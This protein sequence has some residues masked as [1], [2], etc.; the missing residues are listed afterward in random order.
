M[1]EKML[2]YALPYVAGLII[3]VW[4]Q[5]VTYVTLEKLW[6]K[7][8]IPKGTSRH[9]QYLSAVLGA[10]EGALYLGAFLY[11]KPEFIA[12]WLGLKTVVKWRH[13]EYDVPVGKPTRWI[14]G[15]NAYN[16]FLVGNGL[17]VCFAAAAWKVAELLRAEDHP[18]TYVLLIAIA[19]LSIALVSLA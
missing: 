17:V 1:S 16:L 10:V 6:E 15:R 19:L 14:L 9:G 7:L 12:L 2:S 3:L 8:G 18:K 13:W 5:A 4:G 11:G